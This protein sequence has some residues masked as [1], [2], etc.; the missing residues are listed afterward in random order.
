MRLRH[1]PL[2]GWTW[3]TRYVQAARCTQESSCVMPFIGN[4]QNRQIH[5]DREEISNCQGLEAGNRE[6]LLNGS[7]A[8]LWGDGALWTQ[9][10]GVVAQRCE[11]TRH[12]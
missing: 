4:I 7:R 12:H 3:E 2:H 11:C 8:S 6:G 1:T 5:R 9:R 10:E